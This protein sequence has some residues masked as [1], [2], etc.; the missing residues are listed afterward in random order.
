MSLSAPNQVQG[1]GRRVQRT[2]DYED[3]LW[4]KHKK[5]IWCRFLGGSNTAGGILEFAVNELGLQAK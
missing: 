3:A 1:Q 4:E 2:S 5:A